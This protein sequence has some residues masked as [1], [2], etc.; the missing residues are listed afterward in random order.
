MGLLPPHCLTIYNLLLDS[1][2]AVELATDVKSSSR[3]RL[4]ERKEKRKNPWTFLDL[5]DDEM[6]LLSVPL[7][8]FFFIPFLQAQLSFTRAV[9]SPS[10]R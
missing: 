10:L 6:R 7:R 5:R 2:L 3:H 9:V 1:E 8:Q 4:K